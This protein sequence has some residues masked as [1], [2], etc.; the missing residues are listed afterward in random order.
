MADV[1]IRIVFLDGTVE[2]IKGADLTGCIKDDVLHLYRSD[3][4]RGSSEKHSGSFPLAHI[5]SW[6]YIDREVK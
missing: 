2:T 1:D 3:P 5:R 4:E 6:K